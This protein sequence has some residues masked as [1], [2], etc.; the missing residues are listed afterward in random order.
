MI[1]WGEHLPTRCEHNDHPLR[2]PACFDARMSSAVELV[3]AVVC[4][5]GFLLLGARAL[6]LEAVA[7]REQLRQHLE[8]LERQQPGARQR[9]EELAA[10]RRQGHR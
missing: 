8:R 9:L 2:C 7:E 3:V 6:D 10:D 4:V 1:V 5:A